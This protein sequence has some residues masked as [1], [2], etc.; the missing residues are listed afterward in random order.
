MP[1]D[2]SRYPNAVTI[3]WLIAERMGRVHCMKCAH[4]KGGTANAATA[5]L[6]GF[7]AHGSY[8]LTNTI[9]LFAHI[10]LGVGVMDYCRKHGSPIL[11]AVL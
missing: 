2:A 8:I 1:F 10:E 4:P 7:A 6:G 3:G 9:E 5:S 11:A